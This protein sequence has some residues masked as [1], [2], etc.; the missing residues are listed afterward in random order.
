MNRY[1]SFL[2]VLLSTA[3][4]LAGTAP[5]YRI[6]TIAGSD[7][8]GDGGPATMAQIGNI[9]GVAA[10]RLG[11]IY[12]SDTDRHR[13][14]KINSNGIISTVAGTGT[15]GFSGDGGAATLA[16]LNLPYGL[17]VDLAGN[18][19]IADL[20]N[21]RVR[22]M[23][24]D[25]TIN[26]YA[27]SDQTV[28][29]D[30]GPATAALLSGPRNVAVDGAGNLYISEF[31]GH[32]VRKVTADGRIATVAGTG[33]AGFRGDGG[34]AVNAQLAFPAGL[35]LDRAGTLY[36]A[37]SQNQRVR[38][39]LPGGTIATALGGSASTTLLSPIAVA[40]DS[41]G[42]LFV[43][44]ASATV[45]CFTSAGSWIDAAGVGS[46]GFGGDG[47]PAAAATL[48]APR[49]LAV[50]LF[51]NLYIA[52]G[53]RIRRI[54]VYGIIQ[55]VAGDGYLHAV[56]DGNSATAALLLRPSGVALDPAGNL[57]I[58]DTGTQRVRSVA[59]SGAISTFAGTGIAGYGYDPV[60][61]TA[62]ELNSPMGVSAGPAGV[63]L[64]ADTENHLVRRA[65]GGTVSTFAGT[66]AAGAGAEG[67][68]PQVTQLREP[69][70]VCADTAG[71]VYIVD[72]SNH[73]VL[74]VGAS[75][76]I[77][78]V[79]GNGAPGDTGDGG[80]ARLAQ[81]NQ[82]GACAVDSSG[83]LFLAD[84]FNHRIR[85]VT[86]SGII[87]TVAGTG[88][89]DSAADEVA[90]SLSPLNSPQG[91][92]VDGH[93][94]L[95]ISDTANHRVREVTA[96]GVIHTIAG[97]GSSGFAGDGAAGSAA[98][99]NTPLGLLVDGAGNVYFADSLNNRIRRLVPVSSPP[100]DPVAD[101]LTTLAVVNTASLAQG[102]V[103]PGESITIYGA[104]IGPE[105]GVAGTSSSTGLFGTLL[106]GAE[107]RFDGVPAPLFYAQAGQIN[108]QVPYTVAGASSTH[109]ELFYQNQST[110]SVDVPVAAA[111]P[112]L[113]P[114]VVNQDGNTNSR[115][116]PAPRGT[117]VTLYA[118]GDGLT[119]G[120]NIAGLPSAPPYATP[121]APVTLSI[122]GVTAQLLYAGSAP[123]L[124]GLL[125]LNAVVPGG[126][127]PPGQ[128]VVT[129]TVGA[130]TSPV[131]SIWLQ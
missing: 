131:L 88:K 37:D 99:I 79:A 103:A 67:M 54:D 36:I 64:I 19:Y 16:Q 33:A 124:V 60:S 52:D 45:R 108:A 84:T 82:P 14:R 110:G 43:A 89:A 9:Q 112:G 53:V 32:R 118:T 120:A 46:A 10:D 122:G 42:D 76:L 75:A 7:L 121:A 35:A 78:T 72:T 101:P 105:A 29:G 4:A 95:F 116:A 128:A 13:I 66:G 21:N 114:A 93:G 123:G 81:L 24:T 62:A 56:G 11:N 63:L 80:P 41:A 8:L 48:S 104:G 6:E 90:A 106:G 98:Q 71:T 15:A 77:M 18:L 51:G 5:T 23:A 107:V 28:L 50:D 30:G 130:V 94:N 3:A 31:L 87:S 69:R 55:T 44:D 100:P 40:V 125:Q 58:A 25:G 20:G 127:V 12:L 47:A 26:T 91:V 1:R 126:F 17:A 111:A 38:K 65:S 129:L 68:L 86:P 83:N 2:P 97:L 119:N 74:A 85:K 113:F 115:A 34:L 109:V 70:A 39:V 27:G 96:D 22:R 73:R 61:A 59:P 49:D 92:A 57:Y 102:P 117:V